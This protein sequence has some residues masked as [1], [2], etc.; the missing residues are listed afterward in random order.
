MA[1]EL[2]TSEVA[3][4]GQLDQLVL[5]RVQR[6][7]AS[8]HTHTHTHTPS[9][10]YLPSLTPLCSPEEIKLIFSNVTV[11]RNFS[12]KL[13]QEL[14]K[15]IDTWDT[16]QTQIGDVFL[17]FVRGLARVWVSAS[18]TVCAVPLLQG[19]QPVLQQL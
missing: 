11:L 19:L 16:A 6:C 14:Q 15:K 18:L 9:Q 12:L 3:Y 5:V 13:L 10:N 4:C 17:K 7:N 8:L 1:K 2:F